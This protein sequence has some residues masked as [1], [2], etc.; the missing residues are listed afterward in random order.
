MAPSLLDRIQSDLQRALK[1]RNKQ[2]VGTLRLLSA[3]L[4]NESIAKRRE[5]TDAETVQVLRR[6]A[7][8]RR[9]AM[10]AYEAGGSTERAEAEKAELGI[11]TAYLPEQLD[12]QG[13]ETVVRT[14]LQEVGAAGPNDF[15]RVMGVVM[16]QVQGRADG[17]LVQETVK[18]L[19]EPS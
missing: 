2:I 18:R 7:K 10:A 12:A 19:L 13:I 9:E 17:R 5:L 11:L 6:E 15:G 3:A 4:K 1:E 16:K 8:R 14:I